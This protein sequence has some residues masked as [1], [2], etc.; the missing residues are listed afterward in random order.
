[1]RGLPRSADRSCYARLRRMSRGSSPG[2]SALLRAP[3]RRLRMEGSAEEHRGSSARHGRRPR[4]HRLLRL[5]SRR[6]EPGLGRS[7]VRI[8]TIPIRT[9]EP[10]ATAAPATRWRAS[11]TP[12]STTANAHAPSPARIRP[13][14][15]CRAT[16][17][18]SS[19]RQAQQLS[20]EGPS[21]RTDRRVQHLPPAELVLQQGLRSQSQNL[22]PRSPVITLKSIA[23][24]ATRNRRT[25]GSTSAPRRTTAAVATSSWARRRTATSE[26]AP[27]AMGPKGSEHPLRS[28]CDRL[29]IAA[30]MST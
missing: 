6:K 4:H 15:V 1:M 14:P 9:V 2:R 27:N 28:W 19:V 12:S 21:A 16:W 8:R 13:R 11:A 3:P 17:A 18:S 7:L 25:S 29:S 30:R 23:T 20:P 22:P 10:R 24:A 5:P 26:I